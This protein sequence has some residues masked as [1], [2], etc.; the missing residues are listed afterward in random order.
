MAA[1]TIAAGLPARG[2]CP[3]RVVRPVRGCGRRPG[4][5]R[6]EVFEGRPQLGEGAGSEFP[7]DVLVDLGNDGACG[8]HQVLSAGGG[9]DALGAV[10]VGVRDAFE[11]AALFEV[12]EQ[13]FDRLLAHRGVGG[14]V[15]RAHPVR[16]G[17]LQDGQIARAHVSEA[18]ADEFAVD[19]STDRLPRRAQQNAEHR[20][21]SF[22]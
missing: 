16:T 18:G 15:D 7:F 4:G 11:V 20:G 22:A 19:P 5:D 10:V 3:P 13:R 14:D 12:V 9:V 8:G 1:A 21:R 2:S 17:P 6:R